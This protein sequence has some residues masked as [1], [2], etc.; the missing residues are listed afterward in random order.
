MQNHIYKEMERS[1]HRYLLKAGT[2]VTRAAKPYSCSIISDTYLIDPLNSISIVQSYRSK[3]TFL[4]GFKAADTA[5]GIEKPSPG[6]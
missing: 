2:T 4:W 3:N 5:P 1:F 6:L